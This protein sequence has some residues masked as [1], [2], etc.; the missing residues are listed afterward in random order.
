[1]DATF[2]SACLLTLLTMFSL[3]A[4]TVGVFA[5]PCARPLTCACQSR[6]TAA[7]WWKSGLIMVGN[8]SLAAVASF[9]I[10]LILRAMVPDGAI[11]G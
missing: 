9:L 4:I 8:G 11:E 2:I 7:P 5:F 10:G 3:G 1:M 6:F